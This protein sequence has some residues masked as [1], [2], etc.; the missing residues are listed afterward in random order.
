MGS[1]DKIAT[2]GGFDGYKFKFKLFTISMLRFITI[3]VLGK[4]R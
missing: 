3:V 4:I 2:R 1:R